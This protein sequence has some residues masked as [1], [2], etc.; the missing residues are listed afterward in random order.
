M[1]LSWPMTTWSRR[2][3]SAPRRSHGKSPCGST[4]WNGGC[5]PFRRHH[6]RARAAG[7]AGGLCDLHLLRGAGALHIP[8]RR[9][10]IV[11]ELRRLPDHGYGV[12]LSG[13]DR[14]P[15]SRARH[16]HGRVRSL[17]ERRRRRLVCDRL[18]SAHSQRRGHRRLLPHDRPVS[19]GQPVALH[20]LPSFG[21][22]RRRNRR[23]RLPRCHVADERRDPLE[24]DSAVAGARL[25]GALGSG[26]WL[27]DRPVRRHETVG[28]RLDP[29]GERRGGRG[30][31]PPRIGRPRHFRHRGTGRGPVADQHRGRQ[32]LAGP[33]EPPTSCA[34]IGPRWRGRFPTCWR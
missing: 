21:W 4:G 25:S 33:W 11:R 23:C 24:R 27:R 2:D 30:W 7:R 22:L 20:S 13:R 26:S 6:L 31:M 9:P 15:F 29:A 16:R 5:Q 17:N 32:P 8:R 12:G 14:R 19:A 28:Q 18:G 10:H 3:E 1:I 34:S